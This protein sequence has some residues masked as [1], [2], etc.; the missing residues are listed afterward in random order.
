MSDYDSVTVK[1]LDSLATLAQSLTAFGG[2]LALGATGAAALLRTAARAIQ[3]RRKS[4][5]EIIAGIREPRR[6]EMPWDK[7]LALEDTQPERPSV[8]P[9]PACP[10]CSSGNIAT[11]RRVDGNSKCLNCGHVWKTGQ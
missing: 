2:P 3:D 5:D 9:G 7:D 6:L 8:R 1:T 4:L 10:R 11:E